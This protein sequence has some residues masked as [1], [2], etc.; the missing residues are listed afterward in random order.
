MINEWYIAIVKELTNSIIEK[1]TYK[2][3]YDIQINNDNYF[4][5][6][7][8]NLVLLTDN[9]C[10]WIKYNTQGTCLKTKKTGDCNFID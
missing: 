10:M 8:H 4:T 6:S 5:I 1:Y 7:P 2:P 9:R 3:N